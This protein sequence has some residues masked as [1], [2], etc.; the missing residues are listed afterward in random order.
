MPAS[1][2]NVPSP[3]DQIRIS[4]LYCGKEQEVGTRA[5]SITCKFCHKS[6]RLEDIRI[7]E[8]QARRHID[9]CGTVVIEKKGNVVSDEILCGGIVIRGKVK[10]RI[11]SRGPV[12][13]SP[14]GEVT[15]DVSAP[16]LAVGA[17]AVLEGE[18]R[19]GPE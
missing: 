17:G 14:E 10:G 16:A 13:I 11:N 12:L 15:G 4:C 19:I 5:M 6:L 7:K 9:T 2:Y 3:S 18:Y 1:A 8:Y